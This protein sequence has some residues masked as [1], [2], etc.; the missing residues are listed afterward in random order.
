ME[1]FTKIQSLVAVAKTIKGTSFAYLNNYLTEK[2]ETANYLIVAG[3]SHENCLVNDF[4]NLQANKNRIV[5]QFSKDYSLALIE[6]VYSELYDSLEKRLS[7]DKVKDELR[8]QNDST[9]ARSDAMNNG[10][11]YLAKGIFLHIETKKIHIRGL[12]VRKKVIIPIPTE[13]KKVTKSSDKT[14][15]KRKMEYFCNFRQ[16]SI[17]SFIFDKA[18]LKMQGTEF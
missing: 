15:L 14:I 16:N 4:A 18:K 10:F 11:L 3:Y 6:Q 17:R 8:K 7:S 1:N 2:G 13:L 12:Q 5:E 9:I